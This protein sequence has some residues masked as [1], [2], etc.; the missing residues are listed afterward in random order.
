MPLSS[1]LHWFRKKKGNEVISNYGL[2]ETRL[3]NS[4][5]LWRFKELVLDYD[6]DEDYFAWVCLASESDL[7]DF[8]N[9]TLLT[10]RA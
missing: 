9:S 8:V 10:E 2:A 3:Q 7:L 1:V 5:T 6:R 4:E